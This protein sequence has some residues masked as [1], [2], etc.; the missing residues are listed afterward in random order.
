MRCFY[1]LVHGKL[2]W[3]PK[4][5]A[6]GGPETVRPGGFYCHRHV[7]ASNKEQAAEKAFARVRT[8]LER[9][10]GWLGRGLASLD[11][12]AEEVV[13]APLLK[14]LTPENRGHSFYERD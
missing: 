7:L 5:P 3:Q 8:N 1:V 2:S 9:R 14:L 6:D 4:L 11:L 10:T 12:E 13:R